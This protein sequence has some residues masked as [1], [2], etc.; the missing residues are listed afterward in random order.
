M[1][2]F[3]NTDDARIE[4]LFDGR[5]PADDAD[6]GPVAGFLAEVDRALPEQ[7]T[8]ALEASHVTAMIE[9][10]GIVEVDRRPGVSGLGRP[11]PKTVFARRWAI[12]TAAAAALLAFSGAAYAGVLPAPLQH[13]V[14]TAVQAV[15]IELPNPGEAEAP[16]IDPVPGVGALG[17]GN[18]ATNSN[19]VGGVGPSKVD[20]PTAGVNKG[21][22]D[23]PGQSNAVTASKGR[24]T[25][26]TTGNNAHPRAKR[27][28][29]GPRDH[30]P[31]HGKAPQPQ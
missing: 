2:R 27:R 26:A 14:A 6:L 18:G 1:K 17:A 23:L 19:S 31:E 13:A 16:H 10:A 15:G 28:G 8:G 11:A 7:Q 24:V 29:V 21:G 22:Q 25:G 4:R 5:V 12:A 20:T 9:A 30:W 3:P